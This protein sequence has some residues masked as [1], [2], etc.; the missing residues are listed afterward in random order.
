MP[1]KKVAF[2][3][4]DLNIA[5]RRGGIAYFCAVPSLVMSILYFLSF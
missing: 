1:A 4:F 2:K 5:L 3:A